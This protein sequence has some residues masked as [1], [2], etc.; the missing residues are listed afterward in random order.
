MAITSLINFENF[1]EIKASNDTLNYID[2]QLS[3]P[4]NE[5]ELETNQSF[6]YCADF[7][8]GQNILLNGKIKSNLFQD[9]LTT[10][11]LRILSKLL[12]FWEGLASNKKILLNEFLISISLQSETGTSFN[13]IVYREIIRILFNHGEQTDDAIAALEFMLICLH[14][15]KNFLDPFLKDTSLLSN[16][17][18]KMKLNERFLDFCEKVVRER[19]PQKLNK[20]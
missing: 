20:Q 5:S 9:S 12:V 3:F 19:E 16:L 1:K 18:N 4:S 6:L 17:P 11:S 8:L 15:Q 2:T 7:S 13:Y 10:L 14:S